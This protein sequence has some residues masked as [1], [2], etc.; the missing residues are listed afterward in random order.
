MNIL[1]FADSHS[2]LK[3][4]NYIRAAELAAQQ[5]RCLFDRSKFFFV[6]N[7]VACCN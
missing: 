5:L 6:L 4:A 7:T 2:K 1:T 3:C